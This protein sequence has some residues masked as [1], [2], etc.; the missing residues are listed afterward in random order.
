[1][2]GSVS[3][4]SAKVFAEADAE[5][6]RGAV[7]SPDHRGAVA[8]GPAA[9]GVPGPT[10][11]GDAV[12]VRPAHVGI[13]VVVV[14]VALAELTGDDGMGAGDLREV[15][16]AARPASGEIVGVVGGDEGIERIG[17]QVREPAVEV[18]GPLDPAEQQWLARS[19]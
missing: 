12:A 1:M 14:A 16:P 18:A 19:G 6:G 5:P 3:G 15:S 8:A 17:R 4:E 2:P 13:D 9:V 7:V 10:D 11:V